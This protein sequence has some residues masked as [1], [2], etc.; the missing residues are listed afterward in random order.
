MRT[1]TPQG[2]IYPTC[3]YTH[4]WLRIMSEGLDPDDTTDALGVQP[5][6]IQRAGAPRPSRPD[7]TYTQ[8]GWLLSTEGVLTSMDARDHLDWILARLVDCD[9]AF[10]QLHSEQHLIDLC[11]RWDSKS[12]H[13]GPTISPVQM[14]R[15]AELE[16]ELWFDVYFDDDEEEEGEQDEAQQPPSAASSATSPVI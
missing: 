10:K 15:L 14:Q 5:T 9:V 8:S 3:A 7:R 2:P 6:E 4:A 16:I 11:V 12:G 13:G 1:Q